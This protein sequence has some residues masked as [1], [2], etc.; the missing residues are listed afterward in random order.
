M[1]VFL[2]WERSL[3]FGKGALCVGIVQA[4]ARLLLSRGWKEMGYIY[5]IK[6][7]GL[8]RGKFKLVGRKS[9]YKN[10]SFNKNVARGNGAR[11]RG[12]ARLRERAR[13]E[14]EAKL[15]EELRQTKRELQKVEKINK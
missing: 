10:G 6:M 11:V 5:A 13:E 4:P 9:M 8:S 7:V 14:A 2:P 3:N 15:G 12:C 1:S